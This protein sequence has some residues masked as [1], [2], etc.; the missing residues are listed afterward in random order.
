MEW[1]ELVRDALSLS[2]S[3][4]LRV[5]QKCCL[6]YKVTIQQIFACI[7][8]NC[9]FFWQCAGALLYIIPEFGLETR[10]ILEGFI[11][12]ASLVGAAISTT[13][14]GPGADR[15]GRRP[16][17]CISA[18]LYCIAALLMLWSPNVYSLVV[19]RVIDGVGVGLAV[20]IAPL[21]ISE[22]SPAEIRGE[23]NTLPQLLG[24]SGVFL[25]YCMVF[26]ISLTTDPSWRLMLGV[27]FVPSAIYLAI[28]CFFLPESPRWLVSKGR[29]RE[30]KQVLQRLRNKEDVS[31][32]GLLCQISCS[33][34]TVANIVSKR[35]SLIGIL[36]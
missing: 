35:S 34:D 1:E 3:L 7:H 15:L 25:A 18:A 16:I 22:V 9:F 13:F 6:K 20:T 8:T 33:L 17:L 29:T 31:G 27:M 28:T 5:V 21:Y 12:A 36:S 32:K 4:S 14:A 11:V 10:T 19:A 23:L 30:A 2:L 26:F 24:T